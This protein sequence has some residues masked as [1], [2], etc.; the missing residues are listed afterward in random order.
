MP[1]AKQPEKPILT[2]HDVLTELRALLVK[3]YGHLEVE[4]YE[5]YIRIIKP[6]PTILGRPPK[7][8]LHPTA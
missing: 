7:R 1:T 4:V 2:E 8:A 6:T 5:H 3:G